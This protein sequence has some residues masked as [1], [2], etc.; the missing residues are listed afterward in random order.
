MIHLATVALASAL[1]VRRAQSRAQSTERDGHVRA[2]QSKRERES[3][4]RP[5]VRYQTHFVGVLFEQ[6]RALFLIVLGLGVVD[7]AARIT[8]A[9]ITITTTRDKRR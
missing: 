8:I 9:I 3:T 2:E 4:H 5:A 1:C 7:H 6:T